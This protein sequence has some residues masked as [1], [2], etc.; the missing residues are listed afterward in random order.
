MRLIGLAVIPDR[1]QPG[2]GGRLLCGSP[3]IEWGGGHPEGTVLRVDVS[4]EDGIRVEP[5]R[6]EILS[7]SKIRSS[8]PISR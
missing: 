8:S 1:R 7:T 3:V 5:R 2:P 6:L 4:A